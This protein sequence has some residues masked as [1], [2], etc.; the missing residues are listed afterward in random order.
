LNA[1]DIGK[2]AKKQRIS[3]NPISI[4]ISS[5][6]R[7]LYEGDTQKFSK[8]RKTTGTSELSSPV[9][10]IWNPDIYSI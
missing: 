5:K 7:K 10:L 1:D 8:K 6:K 2:S 3:E 9:G 4:Y